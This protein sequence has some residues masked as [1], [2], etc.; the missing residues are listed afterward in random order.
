VAGSLSL[1]DLVAPLEVSQFLGTVQGQAHHRFPGTAGRFASL[2]PWSTLNKVLTQHR[3]EF[4]R[5][6][7]AQDGEVVPTHTYT[8]MVT[9]KR[10][11]PIPRLLAAPFGEHLRNGATLVLDAVQE[12]VDPVAELAARLEHDLRERVQVNL[13]A[14][15]G[16]THGFDVHWDD[17][18]AFILQISGRKRWRVHGVTRQAP[19]H[20][21]VELPPKPPA[22]PIA[23]FMLADGDALYVP[24]GHWHDV[25]AVGEES[26]H[27]TFGFNPA[28][29]IDLVNWLADQ[30]RVNEAFRRDLPRFGTAADRTSRAAQLRA[31]IDELLSPDV[32]DRFLTDRDAQAPALP[33][34]GL[35]WV[36]TSDLLP[37]DDSAEVRLLTP[38][39]VLLPEE[40]TVTLLASGS[41]FVFASAA[42]PVLSAL[43]P[44][45][46]VSVGSLLAVAGPALDRTTVRALLGELITQ[47]LLSSG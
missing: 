8:E 37:P 20:R 33:R 1:A 12:L 42:E 23:D 16:K 31:G 3:L 34:L 28:T 26:L 27:L 15:W 17:H 38:R 6:R 13:Y 39:A 36:A 14:G 35:P 25:S 18:D 29:G 21:D 4:P 9:P 2:L 47:G 44:G 41:R 24:R 45:L 5:L 11:A 32:V 7:L 30:L 19:L 46:P 22:E 43:L 10:G 40:R